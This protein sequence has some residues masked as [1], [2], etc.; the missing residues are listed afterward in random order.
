MELFVLKSFNR[1]DNDIDSIGIGVFTS[2][3]ALVA[4]FIRDWENWNLGAYD[5]DDLIVNVVAF[6]EELRA[7]G[8]TRVFETDFVIEEHLVR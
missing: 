4:A 5:D 2:R 1:E 3:K 6:A 8:R 7:E